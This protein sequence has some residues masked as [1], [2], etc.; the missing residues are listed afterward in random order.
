[1]APSQTPIWRC[2]SRRINCSTPLKIVNLL[3]KVKFDRER[4]T[5]ASEHV[6]QFIQNYVSNNILHEGFMCRLFTLT[7]EGRVKKWCETLP[8]ASIHTL[9]QFIDEIL[10][11]LENYDFNNLCIE[12]INLRK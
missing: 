6:L 10:F 4:I 1:M 9:E 11:S 8:V 5:S 7:F 12:L 3:S 2:V